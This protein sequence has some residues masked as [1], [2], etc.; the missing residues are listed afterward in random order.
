MEHKQTL[1][2][3]NVQLRT[4]RISFSFTDHGRDGGK[5]SLGDVRI[6]INPTR[7]YVNTLSLNEHGVIVV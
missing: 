5:G 4:K 7:Y 6:V 2:W 1:T 3:T